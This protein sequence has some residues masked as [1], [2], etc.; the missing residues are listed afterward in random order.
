MVGDK[1]KHVS[2]RVDRANTMIDKPEKRVAVHI[3]HGEICLIDGKYMMCDMSK[4]S[5]HCRERRLIPL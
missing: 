5:L 4:T 3:E 2:R 1:G